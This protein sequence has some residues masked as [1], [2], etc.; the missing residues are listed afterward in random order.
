MSKLIRWGV[1]L[2]V[3]ISVAMFFLL[4]H[5]QPAPVPLGDVRAFSNEGFI[6]ASE[7]D[8]VARLVA[9]N[10]HFELYLDETTSYFSV[11]DRRNGA[12]WKSNPTSRDPWED[13]PEYHITTTALERQK[14]TLE[15]VYFN[16]A[17][18][19]STINNYRMSIDHPAGVL[20]PAGTRTFSIKYVEN[21]FQVLYQIENL[22]IDY[23]FFPKYLPREVLEAMPERDRLESLAYTGFDADLD[24]YEIVQYEN[25]R[26]LVKRE[27][28]RIFYTEGDYT[29]ERA[30]AE[31][32][33]FGYTEQFERF[34]FE[35]GVEVI[36]HEDGVQTTILHDSVVEPEQVRLARISLYPLFGTAVS[37]VEGVK[38]EGYMVLPDGSGAVMAFNNGKVFQN[39]Y[40]KR[41]YGPDLSM[42]S[43]EM[44]E[45]QQL[46]LMP[47][48]GM[49]KPEAAFAAIITEGA[50]MASIHADI[51]GR[52]DSYNKIFTS[53]A[54][55]ENE[56]V[57]IGS[58][59]NRYGIDLW[60]E[61]RVPT[62]FSVR[63]LFLDEEAADYVGIAHAYR[64]YLTARY[65][66]QG[67]TSTNTVLTAEFIGA[68]DK[69]QFFLGAPY[70]SMRAMTTFDQATH[71]LE[72]IKERHVQ[73]MQVIY[74]GMIN[75]G[76]S[77]GLADRFNV[78]RT[79]GGARDFDT[80]YNHWQEEDVGVYPNVRFM[81][82]SSYN[83]PFDR[84][85]YT[86][87][88][89]NGAHALMFDYHYPT[90]LPYS[91]TPFENHGDDYVIHP[92][93][94]EPI[95]NR[96]QQDYTYD[97]IMFSMLGSHIGGDYDRQ[98]PLYRDTA[99]EMQKALLEAS[100]YQL[101]MSAPFAEVMPYA[102]HI[103]DLPTETT[104]YAIVDYSI[105]LLQLVLSGL[106]D[107]AG[108]SFNMS[109][110]RQ[111]QYK[112]LK[113]LETGSHLKFTLAYSDARELINTPYNNYMSIQYTNWLDTIE[114]LV[115]DLDTIG[116]HGGQLT[117]HA[118]VAANVYA[119]QYSHGL[120]ILINYNLTDVI[121]EG[122]LVP[123]MDYRIV[124]V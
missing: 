55:R 97:T 54:L 96:F 71:I 18:S 76:L 65:T 122:E 73:S 3:G 120:R 119:V 112:F 38:T 74:T 13:D 63:Y 11:V 49:V 57:I 83:R 20:T 4:F 67:D 107:Y 58:G 93:F 45:Q 94:Y 48:Y 106:V 15:L 31:N 41:V 5:M 118:R 62:D 51:S 60:T 115:R 91:E 28:Y 79:L 27:L 59:F 56:S 114:T 103:V 110:E 105:P 42:M 78:E 25:M 44:P 9:A 10:D 89:L 77:S 116:I 16:Q 87:S 102:S 95:M 88:R 86:A 92:A 19:I 34:A 24:A 109:Y 101:M 50:A 111:D 7:L 82:T 72:A 66:F 117:H 22:D 2:L 104:L 1:V 68:Y 43:Y 84:F 123:A 37:E 17:G 12:V 35:V 33:A 47:L 121:V 36:L 61:S 32:L 8:D 53:F 100:P 80:F 81:V 124:G 98:N 39:P 113:A 85:R 75:G 99:W 30:I 69:K 52:V 70:Y 108:T 23:L 6:D 14:A 40:R 46:I 90:R 26:G 21:G 64:D 29:R